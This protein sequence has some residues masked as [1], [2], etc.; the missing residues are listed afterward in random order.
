MSPVCFVWVGVCQSENHG[1]VE[2]IIIEDEKESQKA[3]GWIAAF[4]SAHVP[5]QQC[6][7]WVIGDREFTG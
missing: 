3:H 7:T 5:Y 2:R 6:S 4:F 1:R